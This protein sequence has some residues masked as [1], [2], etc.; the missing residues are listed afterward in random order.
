MKILRSAYALL[1]PMRDT[2]LNKSRC[3]SKIFAYIASKRPIIAHGVGE[4]KSL[5][6]GKAKLY[7]P[8][9]DL[10]QI[11]KNLPDDLNEVNYDNKKFSYEIIARKYIKL[12][13]EIDSY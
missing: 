12:I 11:L 6:E 4:I 9:V 1:F 10:I 7:S 3:P 5:L 2:P 13:K 8:E